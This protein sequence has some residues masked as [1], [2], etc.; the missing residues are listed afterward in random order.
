MN[1]IT[2]Q[3]TG[4]VLEKFTTAEP[5]DE[6]PAE[7]PAEPPPEPPAE[8]PAEP[9]VSIVIFMEDERAGIDAFNVIE[10]MQSNWKVVVAFDQ[11]PPFNTVDAS[12]M[13]RDK[14]VR[15]VSWEDDGAPYYYY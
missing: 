12:R 5:P 15:V 4:G 7:P 1:F 9:P 3:W 11:E 14:D 13:W 2:F 8:P 6:P 10:N